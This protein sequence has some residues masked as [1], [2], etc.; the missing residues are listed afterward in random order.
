LSYKNYL[1]KN[2]KTDFGLT[3]K[4]KK[5]ISKI[6]SQFSQV[7]KAVVFGSRAMGNHKKGSDI[8]L[9]IFGNLKDNQLNKISY[10][11]NEE[12]FLPYKFDLVDYSQISNLNLKKH[13]NKYGLLLN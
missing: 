4:D 11:L 6:I 10:L 8:D 13:I 5:E 12:T 3:D 2:F 9:A 7:E 1:P